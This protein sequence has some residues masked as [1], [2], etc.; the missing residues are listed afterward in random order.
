MIEKSDEKIL[1]A[2]STHSRRKRESSSWSWEQSTQ[3]RSMELL[4]KSPLWMVTTEPVLNELATQLQELRHELMEDPSAERDL[5]FSRARLEQARAAFSHMIRQGEEH[6]HRLCQLLCDTFFSSYQLTSV[7]IGEIETTRKRFT[8]TQG[9][10]VDDLYSKT[11]LDLGTRQLNKHQFFDGQTWSPANVIANLVDYQA[12][13]SND[14][15][16][17]KLT[18]RIKA[19]EEI[20]NKVVDEIFDLDSI[21]IRDKDL[22]HL[23]QYV[24]DIFGIKVVVSEMDDIY[25]VQAALQELTWPDVMLEKLHIQPQQNTKRLR[26]VEVKDYLANSRRKLTG[27]EAIKSVVRWADRTFEIQVQTLRNFMREQQ[28]LTSESHLSFKANR[29][30]VRAQ[31]AKQIPLFGFYQELLRWLFLNPDG[32]APVHKRVRLRIVD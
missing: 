20:W 24:K 13:A 25:R 26:F 10:S 9:M 1:R 12:A 8:I 21:V 31:V 23:S 3:Y 30:Q 28:L 14:Y 15:N 16:I 4:A 29:E 11:D 6:L 22:R 27:W 32:P 5:Q 7:V 17:H 18:S 19:E 2:A